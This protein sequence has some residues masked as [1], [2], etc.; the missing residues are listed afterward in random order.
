MMTR[1]RSCQMKQ[2]M[3][4]SKSFPE[5]PSLARKQGYRRNAE[6]TFT[7]KTT[8]SAYHKLLI[9]CPKVLIAAVN[10]PG[11]G[12]G[13]SS[14]ALF[15]LVYSVPDAYF[16]TPFV[17]WGLC[18]EACSSYTFSKAMGRQKASSLILADER[19][20]AQDLERAGLISKI[21]PAK[22]FMRDVLAIASRIAGLPAE[23]LEFNKGLLMR[24]FRAELLQ[25]N[26]IE[27]KGLRELARKN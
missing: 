17:K 24:N 18:A 2:L 25:A 4:S 27:L 6:L 1:K 10:G 5:R 20:S 7:P 16:F 11:I 14:I 3:R 21:I 9:N 23:S 8:N 12:Y 26:E 13:T 15:D 22:N 19:A